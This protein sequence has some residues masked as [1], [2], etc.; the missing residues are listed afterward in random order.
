MPFTLDAAPSAA[1]AFSWRDP[2]GMEH[3]LDVST[4]GYGVGTELAGWW[5]AGRSIVEQRTPFQDG[6]LVRRVNV[7]TY[8]GTL[9]LTVFGDTL[10]QLVERVEALPRWFDTREDR[11]GYFIRTRPD[12]TRREI[13]A[14]YLDGLTGDEGLRAAGMWDGGYMQLVLGLLAPDP[15]QDEADTTLTWE[16][17]QANTAWFPMT[18]P[19]SLSASN[20]L[21]NQAIANDGD[22]D[23]WPVWTV[24]G[25]SDDLTLTNQ[26]TGETFHLDWEILA[27]RTVVVDTRPTRKLVYDPL[28]GSLFPYLTP[29]SSLW[30]L[31]R[32]A[33]RVT[34]SLGGATAASRVE[35]A[36]RQKYWSP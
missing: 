28:G 18:F 4:T 35:L 19:W 21:V 29:A 25:P 3:L 10:L 15:W 32:G 23:A 1:Q 20:V 24:T 27:G 6:A 22:L 12:G 5:N 33:N 13:P 34:V 7:E 9:P 2:D 14:Y 36:Y 31:A 8:H 30:P 11:P 26:T 16:G 17:P